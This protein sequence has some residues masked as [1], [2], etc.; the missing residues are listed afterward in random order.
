MSRTKNAIR[1]IIWGFINKFIVVLFPFLIRTIIIKQLGS[2]YLGLNSLFTSILHVLNLTELGFSS[3]IVFCMYKPIAENNKE[4]ICA[5]MNLYKKIYRIIGCIIL[6]VGIVLTPFIHI[7]IKGT[8]PA[9]INIY[10]L[11]LIYLF[12]TAITYFL[13]AYK[14][15]LL[16]AHQR[17]DITSNVN[18]IIFILQYLLQIIVL[19]VFRNYYI[20]III[21]VLTTIM[22][23]L[24]CAYIASKKYPEYI[25]KGTVDKK[26]K[27]I[28]KQKV[29]GL[30]IQRICATTRNSLDSIFISAYIGLSTVAIYN[31]YYA[32]MNAL[33]GIMSIITSA[34]TAGIGNSIVT[35]SVD[36]N[37]NDMN[38]F[39]F[40]YMWISGWCTICL[41]C[42]YQPF[43]KIWMGQEYM[44][45]NE[46]VVLFCIYFYSLKIGVIRGAYSDAKGLWWENRYRAI[47]ETIA[48]IALNW[49]L[50]HFFGV[51]GIILAT[52]ISILIINF[53]YGSQ[54]LFK[55][56]FTN[57]KSIEYFRSH[58][59]YAI[60]TLIIACI[61]YGICLL[62]PIE[63]IMGLIVKLIICIIIPNIL[64]LIIYV[65]TK[66]FNEAKKFIFGILSRKYKNKKGEDY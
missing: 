32:I 9:D 31:N 60:V 44:F 63:G 13:F 36:K 57:K 42:L 3:A 34:I 18:S 21:N 58:G 27:G 2:E 50:V 23:N 26:T 10:I 12:N 59:V 47:A 55:H 7:F 24:I 56:Y 51:H 52:L 14:S 4:L 41:L 38:K 40:I 46:I 62:I 54:I 37:Y 17:S 11:Y 35:E 64:Y 45:S 53:G 25:P 66:I 22:N 48:N 29:T 65:K 61:T 19:F 16:T 15:T 1:N 28:I 39:N 30:M 49:I 6:G 33:I 20:F 43:M 5:L 8:Y